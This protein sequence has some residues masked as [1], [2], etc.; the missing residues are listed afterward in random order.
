MGCHALLRGIFLT[1]GLN[2]GLLHCK[3][4]LYHLSYLGSPLDLGWALNPTTILLIE[5]R[6]KVFVSHTEE[7]IWK[8]QQRWECYIYI[9]IYTGMLS[10]S[11]T[12]NIQEYWPSAGA[13]R[14]PWI[15]L[16]LRISWRKCLWQHLDLR[17]LA[18][19]V[20]RKYFVT[21]NHPIC[22]SNPWKLIQ[23][24]SDGINT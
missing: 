24:A 1:Q 14:G 8:W 16:S 11:K 9:P 7:A 20:V 10:T 21:L 23:L 2:P 22:Y 19:R 13:K 18:S 15:G 12:R 17:L 6:R 5:E 3:Q 4:I